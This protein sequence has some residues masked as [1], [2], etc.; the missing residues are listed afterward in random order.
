MAHWREEY[1]AG[2][3]VRDEYEKANASL[4]NACMPNLLLLD[5][6]PE[7]QKTRD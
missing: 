5:S 4:Y 6:Y 1:F 3:G 7:P 2:L